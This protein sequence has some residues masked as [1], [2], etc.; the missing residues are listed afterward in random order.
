MGYKVLCGV[1]SEHCTGGKY[2][3]DQQLPKKAHPSHGQAF[4]CK[5]NYLTSILGYTETESS[6]TF[7]P[8]DGGHNEVL[9][10]RTRFGARL[11]PGKEGRFQPQSGAGT[12][13][14]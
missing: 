4:D 3:T 12:I 1:P 7:A 14:G 6:R 2:M 9:T 11:R 5:V 8:P 10:K 13:T